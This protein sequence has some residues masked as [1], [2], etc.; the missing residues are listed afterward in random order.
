MKKI[1]LTYGSL[2]GIVI[3][4][5]VLLTFTV[6][7]PDMKYGEIIGYSTMIIAF[8]TIYVGIKSCRDNHLDGH[9]NFG[10]ALKIGIGICLVASMFYISLWMIMS[11]TIAKDFMSNY[12]QQS[13]D[14]INAS[15]LSAADTKIKIDEVKGFQEMYK[16]PL[17]KIGMTFL[18]IFPVGFLISLI[19][20]FLLKNKEE[21]K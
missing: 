12:F 16:N 3:S 19:S 8:S 18:E 13:I 1:I 4:A 6:F 20:A 21:S 11:E 15:N 9:I 17:V 10:K 5:M 14:Q 2:S 7:S